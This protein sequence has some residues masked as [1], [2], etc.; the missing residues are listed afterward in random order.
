MD[1]LPFDEAEKRLYARLM[2]TIA[3]ES[4]PLLNAC[5]RVAAEDIRTDRDFPPFDRVAMDGFACKYDDLNGALRVS[6]VRYAGDKSAMVVHHGECVEVMTG[7][8]LPEGADMVFQVELS[9]RN[10]DSVRCTDSTGFKRWSNVAGKGEDIARNAVVISA[11]TIIRPPHIAVAASAGRSTISVYRQPKVAIVTTG[12]EIVEPNEFP[13]VWQIR[14]SNAP[15]LQV[16][17][18][19]K[20]A[21]EA[22]YN[23]IV[24]DTFD[25]IKQT[26]D[27]LAERYDVI[28]V[29]GGVSRGKKDF[30]AEALTANR[31]EIVFS[32]LA[33]K[34][35][36]PLTVAVRDGVTIFGLPGNPVSVFVT[37][38][39]AVIPF[40]Y[41]FQN[42]S[43][44]NPVCSAVL[45]NNKTRRSAKRFEFLPA[46]YENGEVHLIDYHGSGDFTALSKANALVEM[47]IGV[48]A[49]KRGQTVHVRLI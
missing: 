48:T 38:F 37:A 29:T 19:E 9:Q 20:C 16:L 32:R 28:I 45:Q 17:L 34:P 49:L 21:V 18:K 39:L 2:P 24:E 10:G 30:V 7:A 5:G 12:S 36:R 11:G 42:A 27:Q 26:L 15:Q 33:I 44:R 8:P 13:E 22:Y 40:I 41:A 46:W 43:L 4:V 3:T 14:N 47:P 6:D 25:R 31:F 23:G 35:G 1:L